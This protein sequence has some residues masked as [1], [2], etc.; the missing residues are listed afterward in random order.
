MKLPAESTRLVWKAFAWR[1]VDCA[2]VIFEDNDGIQRKRFGKC[3]DES[4]R[5]EWMYKT[6]FVQ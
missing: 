6:A 4:R 3:W 5:G 2:E 1:V